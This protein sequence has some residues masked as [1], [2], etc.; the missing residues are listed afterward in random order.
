MSFLK[1][2]IKKNNLIINY[3]ARDE[4]KFCWQFSNK[5]YFNFK[6]NIP[7]ILNKFN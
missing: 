1:K 6:L 3:I 4:D 2:I 7:K 5:G